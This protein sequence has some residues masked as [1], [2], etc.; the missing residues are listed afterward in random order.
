MSPADDYTQR[1]LTHL[2][3]TDL[4]CQA[5]KE[6]A[7]RPVG[8]PVAHYSVLLVL[9]AVPGATGAEIAR[10]CGVT[11]QTV[12]ALLTRLEGNGLV[13]R[14]PHAVHRS[15]IECSLTDLGWAT[16]DQADQAIRR[17]EERLSEALSTD[18]VAGLTEIL[19]RLR[20]ALDARDPSDATDP[21]PAAGAPS[22][23]RRKDG[24]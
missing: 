21:A 1:L 10:R 13:A 15:L 22:P 11:P 4:T 19:S 12:A 23:R 8:I 20:A 3:L 17:V 6:E 7:L 2:R 18:E 9:S 5:A 16:F 24:T 14:R